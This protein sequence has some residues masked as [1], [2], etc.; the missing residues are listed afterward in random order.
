MGP[1]ETR[2]RTSGQ[3]YRQPT[4]GRWAR[5]SDRVSQGPTR[6][7][8][9]VD[10]RRLGRH[11]FELRHYGGVRWLRLVEGGG[12]DLGEPVLEVRDDDVRDLARRAPSLLRLATAPQLEIGLG[13]L[14]PEL[15]GHGIDQQLEALG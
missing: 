12:D 15:H 14:E 10:R 8:R 5:Q 4:G 7:T 13:V 6:P 9:P 11:S 3:A 1:W 2:R